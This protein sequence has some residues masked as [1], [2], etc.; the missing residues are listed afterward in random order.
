MAREL[1]FWGCAMKSLVE[2]IQEYLDYR[3]R[4]GFQTRVATKRLLL[5]FVAFIKGQGGKHIT[6]QLALAFATINPELSSIT[7]ASRLSKIRQFAKYWSVNDPKTEIPPVNLIPRSNTHHTPHIYSDNEIIKLLESVKKNFRIDPLDRYTY[8]ALFGLLAVTGMR[9]HEALNLKRE[10][11]DISHQ[12]ITI[13]ESKF[14]KSRYIPIHQ[15]TAN[16]L[17][18]YAKYRDHCFPVPKSPE[19]FIGHHGNKPASNTLLDNFHKHLKKI[20][21]KKGKDDHYARI[22]DLRHT[23]V[24]K[25]L[26]RWYKN[27]VTNIDRYIPVLST[28]LGHDKPSSTYWYLTANP[29]LSNAILKR[30]KKYKTRFAL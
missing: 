23:F 18:D 28:Y 6:T 10:D 15:T 12:I 5:K 8:F 25:N 20:G 22:M 27:D 9:P 21:V 17:C 14:R 1:G 2:G 11:V 3:W 19:F 13:H 29:D 26:T 4:V 30:I 7:W 24:I 16:I